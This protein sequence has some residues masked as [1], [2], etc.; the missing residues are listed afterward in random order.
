MKI[1]SETTIKIEMDKTKARE[2]CAWL[3][4]ARK[5]LEPG[6]KCKESV[7]E[8]WEKLN[9][10]VFKKDYPRLYQKSF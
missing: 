10:E 3:R 5:E 4:D 1:S 7:F 9:Y 2:L 8:F 6:H